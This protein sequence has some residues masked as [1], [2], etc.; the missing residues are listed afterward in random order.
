VCVWL[1]GFVPGAVCRVEG[2]QGT[3]EA[4]L[5][6]QQVVTEVCFN[7][8]ASLVVRGGVLPSCILP[9][10]LLRR[11]RLV[12]CTKPR[13]NTLQ[14]YSSTSKLPQQHATPDDKRT[15]KL[16]NPT[17]K[18]WCDAPRRDVC[19]K[20]LPCG[21]KCPDTC[22]PGACSPCQVIVSA[23]CACGEQQA[24]RPCHLSAWHCEKTCGKLLACG[25]HHC[26]QVSTRCEAA[27]GGG[28]V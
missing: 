22:H 8:R 3:H 18:L 26:D 6:Q 19:G 24:R 2:W 15:S 23:Q 13:H 21:H 14:P 1:Q 17:N 9:A 16:S 11:R 28:G 10:G 5:R 27:P 20:L 7:H 12:I 25:R 4:V